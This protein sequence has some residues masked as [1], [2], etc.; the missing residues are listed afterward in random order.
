MRL[1]VLL[2]SVLLIASCQRSGQRAGTDLPEA[3]TTLGTQ[4]AAMSIALGVEAEP[5]SGHA[6]VDQAPRSLLLVHGRLIDGT[7]ADPQMDVDV[8]VEDGRIVQVGTGL[9]VPP[10]ARLV[11]LGGRTLLP[12]FIDAHVHLS[13][14]PSEDYAHGVLESVKASEADLALLGA[15]NA[16]S[17]LEAGFTTVRVLGGTLGD[18]ALRDA[19]RQ[20]LVPGPRMLVANHAIG[21][22]GGHCDATN[23]MH[24]DIFPTRGGIEGGVAD[25]GDEVRRAVR[26]Q[27]KHGA[28]VIKVCATGGVMSQGDA[29]GVS[30]M[31][32]EELRIAV[33]T[34]VRAERKVAAHAHGT[35][36]I[37]DAVWA[38][39]H[40]IEHGSMLDAEVIAMMKK[41]GTFLVPTLYVARAV[42]E[43]A[44]AG[45]LSPASAAKVAEITP[46]MRASFAMAVAAG[47][48]VALGSDAGVFDHGENGHEFSEMVQFGLA[49][50]QAIVAGTSGAA[51]LLGLDNVGRVA[52]GMLADLVIVEG[53]PLLDIT[54]LQR[55]S[56]VVKGGVVHVEPTWVE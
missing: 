32:R 6:S 24:A 36:G 21:I 25:G 11:D 15:R 35:E 54:T 41:R 53:D 45:M 7:G 26:Y 16:R 4:V 3:T 14:S 29:V 22:T 18:R 50:M 46:R 48:R 12:G 27:I 1:G 42:E 51:E 31:T 40:S 33:E 49:P 55:P 30:Q 20:G 44:A 43:Q 52:P 56:M 17:T 38:G 34:A 23:E 47:V 8:L 19:V 9:L 5:A 28:D 39:V 37:R 13:S 10:S 2:A